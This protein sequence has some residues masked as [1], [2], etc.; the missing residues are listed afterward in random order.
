MTDIKFNE[1]CAK[2]NDLTKSSPTRNTVGYI[3]LSLGLQLLG[4]GYW[5]SVFKC[6]W[7][8]N[9]VIKISTKPSDGWLL[10]AAFCM[11]YSHSNNPCMLRVYNIQVYPKVYIALIEKLEGTVGKY[12]PRNTEMIDRI[13]IVNHAM[14]GYTLFRRTNTEGFF[15]YL[16]HARTLRAQLDAERIP[17]NDLHNDNIMYHS[18]KKRV[19]IT[20]PCA[21]RYKKRT[22]ALLI[23]L[24]VK[25]AA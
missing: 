23:S 1:F 5:A 22:H 12:N 11:K 9:K 4:K 8:K 14:K 20:D 19:V 18:K 15:E 10:Y 7:N 17:L 21:G 13:D 2:V 3:G 6:P 25:V 24:G 16:Q